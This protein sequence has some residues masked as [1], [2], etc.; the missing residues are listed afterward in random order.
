MYCR[1]ELNLQ[2]FIGHGM[3]V[4]IVHI[5][6]LCLLPYVLYKLSHAPSTA[7]SEHWRST[8]YLVAY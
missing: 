8:S 4:R 5:T 1:Y 2:Q 3:E 6:T 7:L